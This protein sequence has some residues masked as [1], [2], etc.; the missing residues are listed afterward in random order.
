MEI[1]FSIIL[2]IFLFDLLN[3]SAG[4]GLGTLSA[5]ALFLMGYD[6]YQVIPVLVIDAA[7]SG[8]ISGWF[9]QEFEN[10]NFSFMRPLGG[11][12]KT[13]LL[14]SGVGCFAIFGA[15]LVTHFLIVFPEMI[16]K[17]Y[18]GVLVIIMG[19]MGL[20]GLK[21]R[22]AREYKPRLLAAFAAIGGLNKGIGGG[23]YGP[24]VVLGGI[25]SGIYEKTAAAISQTAEGIVSTVGAVTFFIIMSGGAPVDL[26]LLPSIFTGTFFASIVAPYAVRVFPNEVW[27][28]LIPG[29][30]FSVGILFLT[31]IFLF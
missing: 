18:V 22:Q 11:A 30:A 14:I 5:P 25:L 17:T 21:K 7:I 26:V 2:M 10:V 15:V 13:L 6:P 4:M 24:V 12:T 27:R 29:Y 31:K 20:L 8:W 28:V 1:I 19:F 16:I 3:S 23:G 9:H